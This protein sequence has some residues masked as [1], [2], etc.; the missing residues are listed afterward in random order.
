[1]RGAQET[2]LHP[3]LER[4]LVIGSLQYTSATDAPTSR[5]EMIVFT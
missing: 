5:Q 1:M 4:S 3:S 2:E